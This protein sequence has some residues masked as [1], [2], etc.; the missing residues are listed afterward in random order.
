MKFFDKEILEACVL[1]GVLAIGALHV[2]AHYLGVYV[3][4]G[5]L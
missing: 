5:V 4:M 1:C 2:L 3:A